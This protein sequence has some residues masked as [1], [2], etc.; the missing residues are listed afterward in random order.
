MQSNTL[1]DHLL[2][3]SNPFMPIL[4]NDDEYSYDGLSSIG[5]SN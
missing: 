3:K 2:D 5:K 1:R 4:E